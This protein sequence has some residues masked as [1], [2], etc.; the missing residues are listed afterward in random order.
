MKKTIKDIIAPISLGELI[1]KITILRIKTKKLK[2]TAGKNVAVELSILEN[3]LDKQQ[4]KI[5]PIDFRDLMKINQELWEIEDNLRE[6]ERRGIFDHEFIDLARA[7]YKT[8]DRRAAI[9][10]EINIMHGSKLIEE[11]SYES[12]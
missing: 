7:V 10:R 12:Y 8:N 6:H 11:K 9:K 4:I 2:G 5:D 1:D 3:I